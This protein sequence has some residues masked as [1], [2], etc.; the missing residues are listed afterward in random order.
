MTREASELYGK[1][2][3]GLRKSL[4][5]RHGVQGNGAAIATVKL[6]SMFEVSAP[7]SLRMIRRSKLR[8]LTPR[9]AGQSQNWQ[10]HNA[11]ELALF[12]ARTPSA[13]VGGHAHH[14][15]ADERVEMVSRYPRDHLLCAVL[16]NSH[17]PRLS[18]RFCSRSG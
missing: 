5:T 9:Q 7:F 18:P 6:L 2:L 8:L 14:V 4:A 17:F 16:M 13:H 11:G 12:V 10:Q 1:A 3:I 15:F